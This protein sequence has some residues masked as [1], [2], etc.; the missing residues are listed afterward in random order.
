MVVLCGAVGFAIGSATAGDSETAP[1]TNVSGIELPS[2]EVATPGLAPVGQ[3]PALRV[4]E[5]SGDS[6]GGA[7]EAAPNPET[8]T[9]ESSPTPTEPTPEPE[10]PPPPPPPPPAPAPAPPP[11]PAPG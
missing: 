9:P 2:T 1:V 7:P 10:A 3:V 4:S 5:S 6:E 8:S 11:P